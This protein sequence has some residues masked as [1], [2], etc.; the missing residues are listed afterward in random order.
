MMEKK[1][2]I[3]AAEAAKTQGLQS[4][5]VLPNVCLYRHKVNCLSSDSVFTLNIYYRSFQTYKNALKY[6][7]NTCTSTM[8]IYC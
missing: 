2:L 7:T 6:I 4:L 1:T 8:Q 3:H 5:P